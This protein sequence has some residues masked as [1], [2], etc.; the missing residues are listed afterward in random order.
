MDAMQAFARDYRHPVYCYLRWL[1]ATPEDA[2]D[3]TQSLFLKVLQGNKLGD[4]APAN[5]RSQL[6][7]SVRKNLYL[8]EGRRRRSIKGGGGSPPIALDDPEAERRF[9]L[10]A[11][12]AES[13]EDAFDRKVATQTMERAVERL[14]VEIKGRNGG[15]RFS[16]LLNRVLGIQS[17][18]RSYAEIAEAMG[19]T[20]GAVKIDV[21]R[22]RRRLGRILLEEIR[23]SVVN[24]ADADELRFLLDLLKR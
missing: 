12:G 8:D 2:D 15:D 10:E 20:E 22:L 1:G 18:G 5:E 19:R 16:P 17:E 24:D 4:L 9:Q 7:E 3:L 23:P 6:A 21:H 14:N 11:V 13:P